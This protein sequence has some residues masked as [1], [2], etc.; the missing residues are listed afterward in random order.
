[1]KIL[2]TATGAWGTGSFTMIQATVRALQAMGHQVKV[3]F[4][5]SGA[6][7]PDAAV[8]YGQPELYHIWRFPLQGRGVE[9]PQFPLMIRD[10]HPRNATQLTF[11]DLSDAQLALYCDRFKSEIAR[12]IEAFQPDI[13][14]CQH[15]WL[16][17]Y[18]LATMGQPYISVAHGSDQMGYE[19]DPRIQPYAQRAAADAQWIFASSRSVIE[20]VKTLYSVPAQ[21]IKCV[22]HG[23]NADYYHPLSADKAAVLKQYGLAIPPTASVVTFA[24]KLSR[25]KGID[26]IL[27]ANRLLP[28][29]A[30]I[31]WVIFGAGDIHQVMAE[32]T[33]ETYALAR[34]HFMG[35]QPASAVAALHQ[36]ARLSVMPSRS[37]GFGIAGLE[38][39]ACGLPLVITRCGGPEEFAV[40]ERIDVDAPAQLVEAVLRLTNCSKDQY[41]S[42]SQDALAAAHHYQWP[43]ITAL[44]LRYYAQV[45]QARGYSAS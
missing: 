20:R 38:A 32:Q 36:V 27:K 8:F 37:E 43:K 28:S 21:K 17:D 42:L 4:P 19:F 5:D 41:Q 31:H 25:T 10:P 15:I 29:K 35:H 23:Y 14:E 44:R 9:I 11:K 7:T 34:C 2:L 33:P 24:G 3:F 6:I 26:T 40:G 1:M 30:N 22:P 45:M 12:V 13:I 18:C 39:M 16:M